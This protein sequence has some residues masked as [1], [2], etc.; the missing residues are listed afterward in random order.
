MGKIVREERNQRVGDIL[1]RQWEQNYVANRKMI[2]RLQPITPM[3][4]R[5]T[6]RPAL[7]VGA[8]PSL[9]R[10]IGDIEPMFYDIVAVD[11]VVPKLVQNCILPDYVVALNSVPTDVEKWLKPLNDVEFDDRPNPTLVMPCTIHPE[12][13]AHWGGEIRFINSEVSTGIHQRIKSECGYMPLVVGSNAGT[14]AYFL[15]M[16]LGY[17]PIAYC[18]IDFSFLSREEVLRTHDYPTN[19]N[20]IEMTD[21]NGDVR[22]LDIGWLDMAETFQEVIKAHRQMYNIETF[23]CTEGGIC[24]SQYVNVRTLK[25]FNALVE[26]GL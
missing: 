24:Y 22:F 14:F 5:S 4:R 25:E 12:A 2:Q 17:N 6:D 15:A 10:N 11:K 9:D 8:G 16:Y 3:F 26:G 23:A 7:V 13:Y 1:H 18:G 20:V 19:Y 21:I